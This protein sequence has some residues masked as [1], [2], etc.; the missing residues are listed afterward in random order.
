MLN[1]QCSSSKA[2]EI[3]H[4]PTFQMGGHSSSSGLLGTPNADFL[5]PRANVA[6]VND[7][8][9]EQWH[10]PADSPRPA[11]ED[12]AFD[13]NL[14]MAVDPTFTW[15][16]IGLGLDEPLPP[17]ETIDEL[18]VFCYEQVASELTELGIKYTLRRSIHLR[19]WYTS[20]DIWRQ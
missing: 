12:I 6:A 20:I 9:Y 3:P 19:Q 10:F 13:P 16:M 4:R 11:M 2:S 5:V 8:D 1:S 18:Y 7:Q 14:G 15:E 17:Q